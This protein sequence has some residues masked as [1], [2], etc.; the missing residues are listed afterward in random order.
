MRWVFICDEV[1]DMEGQ[2]LGVAI[3]IP[4]LINCFN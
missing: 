4:G 1:K 3:Y 2:E